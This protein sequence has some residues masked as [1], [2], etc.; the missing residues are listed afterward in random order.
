MIIELK[1]KREGGSVVTMGGETYRFEP[2]QIG[3]HVAEVTDEE[4]EKRFLSIPQY[5]EVK[6]DG[7]PAN[8]A[9]T[10]EGQTLGPADSGD[11]DSEGEGSEPDPDPDAEPFDIEDARAMYEETFGK[12]PHH[13]MKVETI[14]ERIEKGEA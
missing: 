14:M 7:E 11:G 13:A 6:D 3:R 10:N 9:P 2:D 8:V 5:R 4:H 12:K 1:I